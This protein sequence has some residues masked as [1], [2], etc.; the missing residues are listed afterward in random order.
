M[1]GEVVNVILEKQMEGIC[2]FY[3]STISI[4][5]GISTGSLVYIEDRGNKLAGEEYEFNF[6]L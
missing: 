2:V 4:S 1:F 6:K 3:A 5:I